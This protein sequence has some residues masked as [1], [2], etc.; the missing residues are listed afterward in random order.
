MTTRKKLCI[1]G[2][3]LAA[4]LL[5]C[6]FQFLHPPLSR[7]ITPAPDQAAS[8]D[9][10]VFR[11]DF[12]M[13]WF[14]PTQEQFQALTA[15]LS[16]VRLRYNGSNVIHHK[17]GFGYYIIGFRDDEGLAT[18]DSCFNVD[19]K[20]DLFISGKKYI[21]DESTRTAL[22]ALLEDICGPMI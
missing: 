6:L 12:E 14:R 20:G 3:V 19:Y 4:V 21:V 17:D 10:A 18:P 1:V 8:C 9:I 15:L 7:M 5:W 13:T 11:D 22:L 16:P 2:V